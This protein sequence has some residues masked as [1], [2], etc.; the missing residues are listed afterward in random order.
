MIDIE[1][2]AQQMASVYCRWSNGLDV[3]AVMLRN[4]G[5]ELPLPVVQRI[6]DRFEAIMTTRH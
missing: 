6:A 1:R 4:H 5:Q 2:A 3:V